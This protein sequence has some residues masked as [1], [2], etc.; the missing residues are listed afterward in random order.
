MKYL[1]SYLVALLCLS[2]SAYGLETAEM[3]TLSFRGGPDTACS[4][5]CLYVAVN[6]GNYHLMGCNKVR[7][8]P[9]RSDGA[10]PYSIQFP[11]EKHCQKLRL[12]VVTR[13]QDGGQPHV[14]FDSTKPHRMA[15]CDYL[16]NA[17]TPNSVDLWLN[18][19]DD[20][21]PIDFRVILETPLTFPLAIPGL[22]GVNCP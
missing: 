14:S 3:A 5:N 8:G 1:R 13:G 11:V 7:L 17:R 16:M 6:K 12:K 18:D 20:R 10:R 9:C 4:Q 15:R 19:N 21:D 22:R 2:F